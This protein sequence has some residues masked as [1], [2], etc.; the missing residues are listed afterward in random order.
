[1]KKSELIFSFILVPLDFLMIILAGVSA[2]N[3][4]Y[5]TIMTGIRPVIF[6][7][8]FID[9][10]KILLVIAPLWIILF[11]LAGLYNI[12][13]ARTIVKEIYRV[14]LACSTGLMLIVVLIFLRREFGDYLY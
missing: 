7:L 2:Y 8:A 6:N 12:R 4:R 9:Y 13:S 11:A 3:L 1:M 14:T 10:L 5:A